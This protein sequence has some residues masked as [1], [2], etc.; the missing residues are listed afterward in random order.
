MRMRSD[1]SRA[2]APRFA[3]TISLVSLILEPKV[4]KIQ[5]VQK[6]TKLRVQGTHIEHDHKNN[7][8]FEFSVQF[9]TLPMA[10]KACCNSSVK[11]VTWTSLLIGKTATVAK[12]PTEVLSFTTGSINKS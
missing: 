6:K 4:G 5:S 2:A 8:K 1:L 12:L 11:L 7:M 10:V 9:S 3:F